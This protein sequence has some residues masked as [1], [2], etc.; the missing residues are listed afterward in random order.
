LHPRDTLPAVTVT[1]AVGL[2]L[3]FDVNIGQPQPH[4][5]EPHSV[6]DAVVRTV[7]VSE[8]ASQ[9]LRHREFIADVS[10]LGVGER[11]ALCRRHLGQFEVGQVQGQ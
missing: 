6:V 9:P 2:P 1:A 3:P 4:D 5:P 8:P 11:F 7:D 10:S